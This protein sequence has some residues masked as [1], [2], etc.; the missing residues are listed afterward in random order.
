MKPHLRQ[1]LDR[2]VAADLPCFMDR[3]IDS[4]H[5]RGT[6]GDQPL[7]IAAFWGDSELIET[8]LEAGADIDSAGED[9]FTPLHYA[10]EANDV[11]AAAWLIS[12]GNPNQ[13]DN[14]GNTPI[15]DAIR[16]GRRRCFLLCLKNKLYD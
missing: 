4:V 16:L 7:H 6:S 5:S 1:A 11:K 10:I 14:F 2:I 12:K 13:Q 8:F 3:S 9:G 15:L